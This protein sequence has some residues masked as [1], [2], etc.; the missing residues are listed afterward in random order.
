MST[1]VVFFIL[2][3]AI[4]FVTSISILVTTLA[5]GSPPTPSGPSLRREIVAMIAFADPSE[6][7]IYD[8][9]SGWGG[10][11]KA[12]ARAN[13]ERSVI[14]IE[15]SF[16]PW[17]LAA[18]SNRLFG[19]GNLLFRRADFSQQDLTDAAVAICYLS[20]DTLRDLAPGLEQR[21]PPGC[22]LISA[23]FAWPGRKPVAKATAKD[24]F[25][26]PVYL[27]RIALDESQ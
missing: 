10:L 8:L 13:P 3:V 9:G 23:T 7:V 14:G 12:V 24:L 11:A 5:T 27:Y 6:G 4:L 15:R 21:L 1:E 17:A 20:G 2:S 18:V 19:P 25:N 16:I 26:S 22:A